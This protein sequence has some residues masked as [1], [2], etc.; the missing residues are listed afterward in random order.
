MVQLDS[1]M[2]YFEFIKFWFKIFENITIPQYDQQYYEKKNVLSQNSKHSKQN[3]SKS[4][5]TMVQFERLTRRIGLQFLFSYTIRQYFLT[6][7]FEL[8]LSYSVA[9]KKSILFR[10]NSFGLDRQVATP[11]SLLDKK[12][13][14]KRTDNTGH[15][16]NG[17][18][19][20]LSLS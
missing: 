14:R 19:P 18:T 6:Q 12:L 10:F 2:F 5:Y 4:N 3:I 1:Q 8:L 17:R 20:L 11:G 7:P 15:F 13:R 16:F 9:Q